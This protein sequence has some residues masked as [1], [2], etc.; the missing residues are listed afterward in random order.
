MLPG[1]SKGYMEG[2]HEWGNYATRNQ[3]LVPE[4]SLPLRQSRRTFGNAFFHSK[5]SSTHLFTPNTF[6]G[7]Q[8]KTNHRPHTR[9]VR[10]QMQHFNNK[11]LWNT[12]FRTNKH[13]AKHNG[14]QNET[15][16]HATSVSVMIHRGVKK[17]SER[18]RSERALL[19]LCVLISENPLHTHAADYEQFIKSHPQT[20]MVLFIRTEQ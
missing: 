1:F 10:S 13:N 16:Q 11:K 12:F 7:T 19:C 20:F 18:E 2:V 5:K 14:E 15:S 17:S 6:Q 8:H 4:I 3:C 9:I